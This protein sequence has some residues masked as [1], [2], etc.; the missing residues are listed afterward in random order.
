MFKFFF[1]IHTVGEA[2]CIQAWGVK[3]RVFSLFILSG[4]LFPLSVMPVLARLYL[5][6]N[7][8]KKMLIESYIS[9][10]NVHSLRHNSNSVTELEFPFAFLY[11]ANGSSQPK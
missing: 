5:N 7:A 6:S 2:F 1:L 11:I 3:E 8:N 10:M 9:L 4:T